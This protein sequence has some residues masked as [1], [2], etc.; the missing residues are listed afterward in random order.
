MGWII[1]G[2]LVQEGR[3]EVVEEERPEGGVP[4]RHILWHGAPGQRSRNLGA[5]GSELCPGAAGRPRG[6]AVYR[7][8]CRSREG[9]SEPHQ[10]LCSG[11]NA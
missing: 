7:A 6:G 11:V 10:Q 2:S 1:L 3:S 9:L 8:G 4:G 5:G